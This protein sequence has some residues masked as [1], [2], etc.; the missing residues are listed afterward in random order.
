MSHIIVEISF[1]II[2]THTAQNEPYPGISR[3]EYLEIFW[4]IRSEY[5]QYSSSIPAGI[6]GNFPSILGGI[7]TIML[8]ISKHIFTDFAQTSSLFYAGTLNLYPIM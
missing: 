2:K 1:L 7:L 5:E 4:N 6:F 3:L 8:Y